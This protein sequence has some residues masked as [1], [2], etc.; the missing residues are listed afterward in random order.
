MFKFF[1]DGNTKNFNAV[2]SNILSLIT[3]KPKTQNYFCDTL[4]N[5]IYCILFTIYCICIDCLFW[6]ADNP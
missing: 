3:I 5:N 2:I 1:Y 6:T 4:Y